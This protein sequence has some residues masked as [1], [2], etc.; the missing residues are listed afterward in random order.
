MDIEKCDNF[1]ELMVRTEHNAHLKLVGRVE[2]NLSHFLVCL[3]EDI[4]WSYLKL[5]ALEKGRF[6]GI[7]IALPEGWIEKRK[8][9][10][11]TKRWQI[12]QK[13]GNVKQVKS[14]PKKNQQTHRKPTFHKVMYGKKWRQLV[15]MK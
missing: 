3:P 5:V 7:T 6:R 1:L 9:L 10:S 4:H 11:T 14:L 2:G 8:G 12:P 15:E 13:K